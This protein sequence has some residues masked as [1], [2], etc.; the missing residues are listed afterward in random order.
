MFDESLPTISDCDIV[1]SVKA[2]YS[3]LPST[4][5]DGTNPIKKVALIVMNDDGNMAISSLIDEDDSDGDVADDSNVAVEGNGNIQNVRRRL[6]PASEQG[7]LT[8]MARDD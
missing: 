3:L 7:E 6:N 1:A 2:S 5:E 4:L 8:S